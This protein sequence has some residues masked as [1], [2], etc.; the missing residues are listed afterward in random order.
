MTRK[1]VNMVRDLE[2]RQAIWEIIRRVD[3][4]TVQ[5][6]YDRTILQKSSIKSYL[7]GLNRGGYIQ[8]IKDISATKKLHPA[9]RYT[10]VRDVGV[11]APR[12]RKDGS[13]V[14]QGQGTFNMWQAMKILKTFTVLELAISARTET[15]MVKES[16]AKSYVH[17]LANAGYLVRAGEKR[18][19]FVRN[20]GKN[21]P[22]IQRTKKVY[23]PNLKKI[24]WSNDEEHDE[25]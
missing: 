9:K 23:D 22:M 19:R 21:P 6:I 20:T 12:V 25:Q 16:T 7:I 14:V 1:A 5:D 3:S 15:C 4:F 11:D 10:L 17:H 8:E 24:V 13:P 2:T 18:F